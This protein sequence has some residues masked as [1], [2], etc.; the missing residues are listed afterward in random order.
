MGANKCIPSWNGLKE[1][2]HGK[3]NSDIVLKGTSL[4]LIFNEIDMIKDRLDKLERKDNYGK[5]NV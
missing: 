4:M 1:F 2:I 5:E 3:E